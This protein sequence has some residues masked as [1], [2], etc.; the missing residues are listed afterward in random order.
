MKEVKY[1]IP[2]DFPVGLS[3][4]LGEV[5]ILQVFI[6]LLHARAVSERN[7]FDDRFLLSTFEE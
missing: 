3:V 5:K 6:L 2:I 1:I 4:V 7:G